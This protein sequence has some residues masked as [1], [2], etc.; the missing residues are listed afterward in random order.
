MGIS[1]GYHDSSVALIKDGEVVFAAQEERYSRIKHDNSFPKRSLEKAFQ[2]A[3]MID[4]TQ[5]DY[6]VYYEN[7]LTKYSRIL[8]SISRNILNNFKKGIF[9]FYDETYNWID[10]DKFDVK[11]KISSELSFPKEKISICFHHL[12]HASSVFYNSPFKSSS[13]ITIDGVGEKETIT[14]CVGK[15]KI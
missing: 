2:F 4:L 6:I 15:D 9:E 7:S 3:K 5:I 11:E 14:Y 13:I 12:S 10:D 8:N 1:F